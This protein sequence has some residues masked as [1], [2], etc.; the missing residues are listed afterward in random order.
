MALTD[1]PIALGSGVDSLRE[2]GNAKRGTLAT[3]ESIVS[4]PIGSMS[5]PPKHSKLWNTYELERGGEA[6]QAMATALSFS[7]A[8]KT[9]LLRIEAEGQSYL[10]FLFVDWDSVNNKPK[11]S[12]SR[13]FLFVGESAVSPAAGPTYT[14]TATYE[15]LREGFD[16]SAMF[17]GVKIERYVMFGNGVD[18]CYIYN[19]STRTLH[20]QSDSAIPPAPTISA[21]APGTDSIGFKDK[22]TVLYRYMKPGLDGMV[23]GFSAVSNEVDFVDQDMLVN[24]TASPNTGFTHIQIFLRYESKSNPG[25]Y[26]WRNAELVA[27]ATAQIR[28]GSISWIG[29]DAINSEMAGAVENA[30]RGNIF[31]YH[32]N[33]I[34][35]SGNPD[36]PERI[37]FSDPV[38]SLGS[39][40]TFFEG[41]KYATALGDLA[42]TSKSKITAMHSY[43]EHLIVHNQDSI[44][45]ITEVKGVDENGVVIRQI[46]D[47]SQVPSVTA[48]LNQHCVTPIADG[49][50]VFLGRDFNLYA[51]Q[52]VI[53]SDRFATNTFSVGHIQANITTLAQSGQEIY[54]ALYLDNHN[55]FVWIA[56]NQ[57]ENKDRY[58]PKDKQGCLF[59]YSLLDKSMLGPFYHPVFHVATFRSGIDGRAVICQ[60]SGSLR[61]WHLD[62]AA[63][64]ANYDIVAGIFTLDEAEEAVD[65][66][67]FAATHKILPDVEVSERRV[68][69]GKT[70]IR[71]IKGGH[72]MQFATHWEDFGYPTRQKGVYYIVL[73]FVRNSVCTVY[74]R[75]CADDEN[76]FSSRWLGKMTFDRQQN[77][78]IPVMISGNRIRV[79]VWLG[80]GGTAQCTLRGASIGY[81]LQGSVI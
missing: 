34:W 18:P 46:T 64:R 62:D 80:V 43:F 11:G 42:R 78:R 48:A 55:F 59:A 13:G 12:Y 58:Q 29:Y 6:L 27:N 77:L 73:H 15:K 17:D 65:S 2:S 3:I 67:G 20:E 70:M 39:K 37:W 51:M 71:S 68:V 8:T 76:K 53:G 45:K 32:N 75:V 61:V 38:L 33:R 69:D 30:V 28:L 9:C 36:H 79:E 40:P 5:Q 23:S 1:Y 31:C 57:S 52:Q 56:C 81:E 21:A 63:Y 74:V 22:K 10:Q 25:I 7:A 26:Y 72:R 41:A 49:S 4:K 24:V 60:P 44:T 47:I 50:I 16:A 66:G 14:T 35:I 19:E 54:P